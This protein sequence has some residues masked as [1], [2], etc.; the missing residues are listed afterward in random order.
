MVEIDNILD[1][2]PT[3]DSVRQL[4]ELR[5]RNILCFRELQSFND[6][7]KFLNKHPLLKQYSYRSKMIELK[8]NK[9]YEFLKE[10][11]RTEDNIK[12]Y[13]SYLNRKNISEDDRT[14][15]ENQ[16]KKHQERL[17]VIKEVMKN[18]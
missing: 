17:Q 7:G 8:N 5:I 4:A 16:L 6:K 13:R 11:S 10:Y 12:R 1:I 15:W 3:T 14:K 2:N 9:S 18:E